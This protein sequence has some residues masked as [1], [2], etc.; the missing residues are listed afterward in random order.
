MNHGES[1]AL[2]LRPSFLSLV[3]SSHA[4]AFTHSFLRALSTICPFAAGSAH[5][6]RLR[7]KNRASHSG[8]HHRRRRRLLLRISRDGRHLRTE[9]ARQHHLL[10]RSRHYCL[11]GVAILS[12]LKSKKKILWILLKIFRLLRRSSLPPL[13][14]RSLL[15]PSRRRLLSPVPRFLSFP[16]FR[17]TSTTSIGIFTPLRLMSRRG[18]T[19]L[20]FLSPLTTA[21][22]SPST[23]VPISLSFNLLTLWQ[24]FAPFPRSLLPFFDEVTGFSL[25][26]VPPLLLYP[27]VRCRL[28]FFPMLLL[29]VLLG[30][31]TLP[32]SRLQ[33]RR[34]LP[35]SPAMIFFLPPPRHPDPDGVD[36]PSSVFGGMRGMGG[37]RFIGRSS[38]SMLLHLLCTIIM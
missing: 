25:S 24:S 34:L 12:P 35:P 14:R 6:I 5:E 33:P 4:S 9:P 32:R 38:S 2:K 36:G 30:V 15:P 10:G 28:P 22:L 19:R 1:V 20:F 23:N 21:I 16:S 29:R 13:L 8:S 17:A 11:L 37:L 27:V 3:P 26:R 31:M 18:T 7:N